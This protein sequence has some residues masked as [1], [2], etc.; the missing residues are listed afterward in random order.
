MEPKPEQME[1]ALHR[2]SQTG[3]CI[4]HAASQALEP[5]QATNQMK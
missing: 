3:G 5:V 2:V 1:R 4:L